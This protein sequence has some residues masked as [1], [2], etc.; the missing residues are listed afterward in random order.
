V[1]GAIGP[2]RVFCSGG[3]RF[4][5]DGREIPDVMVAVLDYPARGATPAFNL[6]LKVNYVDGGV[7]SEWGETGFRFVGNEGV[8]E[9]GGGGATISRRPPLSSNWDEEPA[10]DA[11]LAE[12]TRHR[13]AAPDGYDERLDHFRGFFASV[14]SR[15]P[16]VED[17]LFGLR[18][19]APALLCNL[20]YGEGRPV[21]WDPGVLKVTS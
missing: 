5:K 20:S 17:G 15:K 4:W 3:L 16:V 2:S 8:L 13:F 10:K 9:L 6:T 14:R 19:A 11:A 21:G 1:T 12:A 7:A 18:A